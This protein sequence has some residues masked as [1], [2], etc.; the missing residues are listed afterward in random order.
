[1]RKEIKG[2]DG[3]YAFLSNFYEKN[4]WVRISFYDE[5][6]LEKFADRETKFVVPKCVLD[7]NFPTSEHMFHAYKVFKNWKY[8]TLDEIPAFI[9]FLTYETPGQAKR[10]GRKIDLNVAYWDKVK[11]DVMKHILEVKFSKD[12]WSLREKL[13]ATEDAYLEETNTWHDTY[14]GVCNGIGEN[15]LGKLLMEIREEIKQEKD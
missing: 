13:K 15:K 1:M 5:A 2:F 14:W 7:C 12:N 3:E 11:D 6:D 9:D 4:M 10:A 8:P